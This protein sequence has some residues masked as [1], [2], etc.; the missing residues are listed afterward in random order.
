MQAAGGRQFAV[1]EDGPVRQQ[2][3]EEVEAV[4]VGLQLDAVLRQAVVKFLEEGYPWIHGMIS[5]K[6]PKPRAAGAGR[7]AVGAAAG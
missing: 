2:P 6:L 1:F 3:G 4:L 7:A 5:S